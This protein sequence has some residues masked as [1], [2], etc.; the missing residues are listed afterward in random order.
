MLEN[1]GDNVKITDM[2]LQA[3]TISLCHK[4]DV[5]HVKG[6]QGIY[7]IVLQACE[8]IEKLKLN[9]IEMDEYWQ[10]MMSNCIIEICNASGHQIPEEKEYVVKIMVS[11][12][13]ET[14]SKEADYI[15]AMNIV[16]INF[17]YEYC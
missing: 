8:I 10:G 14:I 17:G 3:F 12:S 11:K 15:L 6:V 5:A 7:V 13:V 9:F 16:D 2:N 4:M 1:S